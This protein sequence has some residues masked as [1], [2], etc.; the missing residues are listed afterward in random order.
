MIWS[1]KY[2]LGSGGFSLKKR[3]R[4]IKSEA[5]E[6]TGRLPVAHKFIARANVT[7]T[8]RVR[9][10][11]EEIR[12]KKNR[13]LVTQF[14]IFLILRVIDIG[15]SVAVLGNAW[16]HEAEWKNLNYSLLNA[17]QNDP[18]H[19]LPGSGTP[20]K[21]ISRHIDPQRFIAGNFN[22][23]NV[24][25]T[26][27]EPR[28]FGRPKSYPR[29]NDSRNS[30]PW[31][32]VDQQIDPRSFIPRNF[33]PHDAIPRGFNQGETDA[34]KREPLNIKRRSITYR[35]NEYNAE[36]CQAAGQWV[37]KTLDLKTSKYEIILALT[38][39]F[40]IVSLLLFLTHLGF[41]MVTLK[42]AFREGFE[43]NTR[44]TRLTGNSL[45]SLITP[46]FREVPL[47]CLNVELLA[48]RSG[49]AGLAC[50]ACTF[51]IECEESDHIEN[52]LNHAKGLLA[53]DYSVMLIN[54]F[55]K[56]ISGFYRL[57]RFKDFHV[58]YI[59]VCASI[60]F[61]FLYSI[62]AFTPAM[63]MFIYRYFAIPGLES[64]FLHDMAERL[65]VVGA[66]IWVAF[67]SA[68]V[69]CPILYAIRLSAD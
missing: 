43:H 2:N 48:L 28:N 35:R 62:T 16:S 10:K 22:F 5:E 30:T 47:S 21:I 3:D 60:V 36:Y 40:N 51:A 12:H 1:S 37:K 13:G 42:I 57:F 41:W 29:R 53:F 55:W 63:F 45:L 69:C 67:V 20:R 49:R 18:K 33:H 46:V 64:P 17:T 24:N 52:A 59:R 58:Y 7:M 44:V 27:S 54:S 68:G 19:S 25:H 66:T 34:R 26:T 38:L 14:T 23:R 50:A 65:V 31:K 56:G 6:S 61:G 39:L 32:H 15:A 8:R 4:Q 9:A 11:R